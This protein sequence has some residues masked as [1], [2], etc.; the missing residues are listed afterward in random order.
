MFSYG[1]VDVSSRGASGQ[2]GRVAVYVQSGGEI[3]IIIELHN[4]QGCMFRNYY[5]YVLLGSPG[6]TS[7]LYKDK[8]VSY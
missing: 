7:V 1:V 2:M 4:E 5:N 8:N 3:C 6:T